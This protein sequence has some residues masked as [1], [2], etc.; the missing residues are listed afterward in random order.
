[1]LQPLEVGRIDLCFENHAWNNVYPC[2]IRSSPY[3]CFMFSL[4]N[5]KKCVYFHTLMYIKN[6]CGNIS[7]TIC[8][9]SDVRKNSY[10]VIEIRFN[11]TSNVNKSSK[12][13]VNT[14]KKYV[15]SSGYAIIYFAENS[16]QIKCFYTKC[17]NY[18]CQY[19]YKDN[20]QCVHVT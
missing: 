12:E 13:K 20:F 4:P 19:I 11:D 14:I 18:I 3:I 7:K 9:I 16:K 15:I 2:P 5:T 8:S 10:M 17:C 6:W 1:M